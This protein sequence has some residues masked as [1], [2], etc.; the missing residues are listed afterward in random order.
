MT[1][2]GILLRTF[3]RRDRWM[4]L[5][6]SLGATLLYWSQAVSV[7]GLYATQSE[8][9]RAAA[10]MEGNAALIAMAG[11][12]GPST[13]LAARWPGRRWRSARSWPV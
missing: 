6:W 13:P 11:P 12:A 1:G 10:S 9:N 7:E 3:L 5:W 8:F 2:T 4:L